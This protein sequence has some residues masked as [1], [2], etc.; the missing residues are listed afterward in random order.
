MKTRLYVLGLLVLQLFLTGCGQT[1]FFPVDVLAGGAGVDDPDH[2][3]KDKDGKDGDLSHLFYED[4]FIKKPDSAGAVDIL[5]VIDNSGSMK[6]EQEA[7]AQNFES[8]IEEFVKNEI[9]FKMSIITTDATIDHNGEPV[10][11]SMD[12]LGRDNYQDDA[13]QFFKDFSDMIKVGTLGSGYEKGL[14]TS[15]S[16]LG[17][18]G[19]AFIRD[20]AN[21]SIIYVSDEE[22]QS[23]KSVDEYLSHY[24]SFKPNGES[25]K[26]YSI[27]RDKNLQKVGS[28][29]YV[30]GGKRYIE[31]TDKTKGLYEE[32]TG[33]FSSILAKIGDNIVTTIQSFPLTKE[34]TSDNITVQIDGVELDNSKWS[35]DQTS[36][37]ISF[38]GDYKPQVGAEIKVKYEI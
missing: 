12:S 9:D 19:S 34:P 7:L 30:N 31:V 24:N 36:N 4:S 32:I 21:L 25:L 28:S 22:D 13:Q 26:A 16:F 17:K 14:E 35:Y 10:E 1:N 20:D 15:S 29:G 33:E 18:Y 6:D 11:G 2:F 8:F 27:V 5:W 38:I 23:E 3:G 37:S